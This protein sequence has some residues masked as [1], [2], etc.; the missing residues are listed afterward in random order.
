M[1]Y[2]I[3]KTTSISYKY[4]AKPIMFKIPPDSVHDY[5]TMLGSNLQNFKVF[6]S[7]VSGAY[8]YQDEILETNLAGVKISNP[9]G[10]SAGFD[11]N[12]DLALLM[13]SFGFGFME[14][15][16]ITYH[17]TKGNS[18]PWFY[19]LPKSKSLI[20][21]KGLNNRGSKEIIKRISNYPENTFTDFPLNISVAKTNSPEAASID[22]AITDYID[23][24]RVI[25]RAGVGQIITLNI[26]CPNAFGGEHFAEPKRLEKLLDRVDKLD[27]VQPVFLK[28]PSDLDWLDFAKL[29]D[30]AGKHKISGLTMVNLAKNRAKM[31][32]KDDLNKILPDKLENIKGNMSGMLTQKISDD[33]IKKTRQNY[34][35]KFVIIGV[36]GIFSGEDAYRK[37]L[38]GADAVELITGVIFEGPQLIGQINRDIASFLRRDGFKNISEAVGKDL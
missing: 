16:S 31:N 2:Q 20:V 8:N 18:R 37:I 29:A 28:M 15:G 22:D 35:D 23:S 6:R 33:L 32:F 4:I 11:N 7:L 27:L 25:K 1:I 19:R 13:K 14:G 34:G 12:I 3:S 24:L 30:V 17:P 38:L 5:I 10:L 21:N 36:G 26:T 9:V